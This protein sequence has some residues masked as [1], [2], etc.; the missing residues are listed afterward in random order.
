MD[1]LQNHQQQ[2]QTRDFSRVKPLLA[3]LIIIFQLEYKLM[4]DMPVIDL[5]SQAFHQ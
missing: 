1:Y 3:I 5:N 4:P 2:C